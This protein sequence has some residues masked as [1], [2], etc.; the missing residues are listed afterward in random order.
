[1]KTWKEKQNTKNSKGLFTFN[2][3]ISSWGSFKQDVY[4]PFLQYPS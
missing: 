2:V 1:M 3:R 4:P